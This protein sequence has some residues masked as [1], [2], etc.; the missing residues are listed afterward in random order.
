MAICNSVC[1]FAK[2]AK[3]PYNIHL[4]KQKNLVDKDVI[5]RSIALTMELTLQLQSA[6]L[7]TLLGSLFAGKPLTYS[8][9]YP[10]EEQDKSHKQSAGM[11]VTVMKKSRHCW[12]AVP[13]FM[14]PASPCFFPVP[15]HTQILPMVFCKLT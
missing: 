11:G 2:L 1:Q 3:N 6:V 13:L 8:P 12:N 4:L 7:S 15:S 10:T 14:T 5:S 9:F